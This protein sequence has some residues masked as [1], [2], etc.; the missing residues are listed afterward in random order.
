MAPAIA[1][2][3]DDLDAVLDVLRPWGETIRATRR[4]TSV[5]P[6]TSGPSATTDARCPPVTAGPS[7][8][9]V[10]FAG[11][12]HP[13]ITATHDKTLELTRDADISRRATCV[14]GVAGAHDDGALRSL[15]G[16]V[17]VVLECDGERD[18]F[19]ATIS[20]FFLGDRLVG[21]P[22]RAGPARR[23]V[24]VRRVEDRGDLDRALVARLA[25]ARRAVDV[26]VRELDP[27]ANR[28]RCAVRRVALPIGNDADIGPARASRCWS[29]VDLVLAE[30][31][32]R[33]RALAQRIGLNAAAG[34][35]A[36]TI[37]TRPQR[38]D[39]DASSSCAAARASRWSATR[40]PRC[41]ATRATSS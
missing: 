27:R 14:L 17:E 10:A 1:A 25:V 38:V 36:T 16:R 18:E 29:A 8:P 4:R 21:V 39:G 33:F 24:R 37:T 6:S 32:R 31:T 3:G 15:R 9:P 19:T 34:R 35:R 28:R 20:P 11:R 41:A 40:A 13:N 2:L 5:G 26:T 12:G 22:A 23:H 7:M 30:D